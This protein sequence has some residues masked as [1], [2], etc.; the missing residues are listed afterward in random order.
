MPTGEYWRKATNDKLRDLRR[1][2]K[3]PNLQVR[4]AIITEIKRILRVR[5]R[6]NQGLGFYKKKNL[7]MKA[8]MRKRR[9]ELCAAK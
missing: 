3:H 9:K 2:R 7:Y 4:A 1:Y 5:D 8:Y 6:R